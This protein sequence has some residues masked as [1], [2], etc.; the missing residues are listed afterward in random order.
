MRRSFSAGHPR[1]AGRE[2]TPHT[3]PPGPASHRYYVSIA[4]YNIAGLTVAKSLSSVHRCLIDACRT[5]LV[6]GGSLTLWYSTNGRYGEEWSDS[7]SPVQLVGF[8]MLLSGTCVYYEVVKLPC[9]STKA[10]AGAE[11]CADE[12]QAA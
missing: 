2:L 12:V 5:V 6:W 4:F 9:W 8:L 10:N 3:T 11:E 7:T 1:G